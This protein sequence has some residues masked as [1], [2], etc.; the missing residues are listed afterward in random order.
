MNI[1][2]VAQ[3]SGLSAKMIRYY[4][5]QGLLTD[6]NRSSS[7]YRSYGEA[8][9]HQLRFIQRARELG[10]SLAEIRELLS[11][12]SDRARKSA[13]VKQLALQ[14]IAKLQQR[15]GMLQQMV[16]SLQPLTDCCAGDEGPECP[17]L[18]D[19]QS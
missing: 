19:L 17:I 13:D 18:T 7:G 14:H 8:E 6:V 16:D 10:F 2:Q 1:G 5:Q 9:L 4:E 12:W 11:L 3:A 15:I